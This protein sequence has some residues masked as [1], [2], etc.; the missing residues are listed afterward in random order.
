MFLFTMVRYEMVYVASV[1]A[2]FYV[3][4]SSVF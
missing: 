4:A 3:L 2:V 1:V